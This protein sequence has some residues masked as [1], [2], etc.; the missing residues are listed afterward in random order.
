MQAAA[1]FVPLD[2]DDST[3]ELTEE[4]IALDGVLLALFEAEDGL[5]GKPTEA[6]RFDRLSMTVASTTRIKPRTI[7]KL[8]CFMRKS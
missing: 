8:W 1:L 2:T 5:L 3:E 4:E 7:R 6:L